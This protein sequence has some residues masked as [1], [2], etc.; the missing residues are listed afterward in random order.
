[1]VTTV[2]VLILLA[3]KHC[4]DMIAFSQVLLIGMRQLQDAGHSF[5]L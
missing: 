4:P 1:M 3:L 5:Q 2:P